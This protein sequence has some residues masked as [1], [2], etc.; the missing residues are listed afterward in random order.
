MPLERID[1][2]QPSSLVLLIFGDNGAG[3]THL[4]LTYPGKKLLIDWLAN[5]QVVSRFPD[6]SITVA[7]GPR[8]WQPITE[9]WSDK[10]ID[11]HEVIIFDNLTGLYRFLLDDVVASIPLSSKESK[12][13]APGIPILRDYGLASERLR[14]CVN[15]MVNLSRSKQKSVIAI[16]HVRFE[17][18]DQGANIKGYPSVPGQ[19]PA[20]VLSLFP[21]QIYLKALSN[22]QRVAY[23]LPFDIFEGGATR[24][25]NQTRYDN[26]NLAT[27]Y[28]NKP[29]EEK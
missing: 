17:K 19:V 18:N 10:L 15:Q 1:P 27:M 16:C 28:A 8:T 26:P 12:R 14:N 20:Y 5:P 25:L 21:E 9:M 7:A 11:E 3:K 6:Q 24:I 2:T 4:A 13:P 22:G 29:K 23:L